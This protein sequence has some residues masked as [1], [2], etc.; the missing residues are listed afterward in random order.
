MSIL[1]SRYGFTRPAAI[2]ARLASLRARF[3]PV[4]TEVPAPV[5]LLI[6]AAPIVPSAAPVEV[7]D[8]RTFTDADAPPEM[9]VAPSTGTPASLALVEEAARTFDTAYQARIEYLRALLAVGHDR[10]FIFGFDD[11]SP[12]KLQTLVLA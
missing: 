1:A 4:A 2:A 12:E 5:L 3:A 9:E 11:L 10:P 7:E 6:P 8:A